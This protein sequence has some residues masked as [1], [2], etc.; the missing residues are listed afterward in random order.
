[1]PPCQSLDTSFEIG[2]FYFLCWI[3]RLNEQNSKELDSIGS[4]I[5]L[6]TVVTIKMC[7]RSQ[8]NDIVIKS[9]AAL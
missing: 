3:T 2:K 9:K 4:K 8:R 6:E 1:V 5:M 7:L